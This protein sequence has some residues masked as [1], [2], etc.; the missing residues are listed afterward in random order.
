[1]SR[2]LDQLDPW[3]LNTPLPA[4]TLYMVSVDGADYRIVQGQLPGLNG[5]GGA[6][7]AN[8]TRAQMLTFRLEETFVPGR[9]YVIYGRMGGK[10]Q[11]A[12]HAVSGNQLSGYASQ[13]EPDGTVTAGSYNLVTD[14]FTPGVA[15]GSNTIATAT[16]L[17]VVRVGA[18]LEIDPVTGVLSAKGSG[19]A[20]TRFSFPV[21]TPGAQSIPIP[22]GS[23]DSLALHKVSASFTGPDGELSEYVDF[24]SDQHH[25]LNADKTRLLITAD[26]GLV[27]GDTVRVRLVAGGGTG[28]GGDGGPFTINSSINLGGYPAGPFTSTSEGHLKRLL[29]VYREPGASLTARNTPRQPGS[30]TQVDLLYTASAGDSPLTSITVNGQAQPLTSPSGAV[31]AATAANTDTTFTMVVRDTQNHQAST[32][33]TVQYRPL[34]F[35]FVSATDPLSLSDAGISALVRAAAGFEF[36]SSREQTRTFQA[37]GQYLCWAWIGTAGNGSFKVNGL[38]NNA[39]QSR[40]FQFLNSVGFTQQFIINRTAQQLTGTFTTEVF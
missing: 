10:P 6:A 20:I 13:L 31:T 15:G 37:S 5:S 30:P 36:S 39:V 35:W 14:V 25:S 4:Q 21:T 40:S 27:A 9:L 29:E 24:I 26:A 23:Y 33:T 2:F 28:L 32:S 12:M 38:I 11:I 7:Y 17:G 19:A 3:P 22:A 18:G 16:K 34:R 8:A 1:M